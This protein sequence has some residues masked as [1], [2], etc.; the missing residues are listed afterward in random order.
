MLSKEIILT[1]LKEENP[2]RKDSTNNNY[3]K[4]LG[5]ILSSSIEDILDTK[6]ITEKL[7]KYKLGSRK[8][9]L[10]ALVMV[11]RSLKPKDLKTSQKKLDSAKNYYSNKMDEVVKEYDKEPKNIISED[12]KAHKWVSWEDV[13]S[14]RETL[15]KKFNKKIKSKNLN[16]SE[17]RDIQKYILLCLYS[18]VAPRRNAD[19]QLMRVGKDNDDKFNYF[20]DKKFIFNNY[21]TAGKYNKQTIDLSDDKELLKILNKYVKYLKANIWT[22]EYG[23]P[24]LCSLDGKPLKYVNSI[25][26]LLNSIFKPKKIGVSQLRKI[27]L[28]NKYGDLQKEKA[29]DAQEMGN[30]IAEQDKTYIKSNSK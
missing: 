14:K 3:V 13:L 2:T 17:W 9:V 6:T 16:G 19:Y 29:K 10:S 28:T 27:Y 22:E 7:E 1:R 26:K 30:S 5:R 4:L 11:L 21:K 20:H 24:L 25:T 15:S 23:Y 8:T 18:Y 12:E